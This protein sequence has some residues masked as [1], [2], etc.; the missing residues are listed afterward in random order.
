[1]PN[2]F[3]A[4][5]RPDLMSN[6]D[7]LAYLQATGQT[8]DGRPVPSRQAAPV[9]DAPTSYIDQNAARAYQAQIAQEDAQRRAAAANK[10]RQT[11]FGLPM[12]NP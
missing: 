4:D 5:G 3:N 12:N 11:S 6:Q 2:T 1:M 9:Q 8:I 10:P 7:Q